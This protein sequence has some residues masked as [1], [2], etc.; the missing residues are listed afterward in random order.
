LLLKLSLAAGSMAM[1]FF[2]RTINAWKG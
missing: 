1:I 2:H